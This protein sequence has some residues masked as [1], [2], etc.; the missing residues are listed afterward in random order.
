[1]RSRETRYCAQCN[2]AFNPHYG[3]P[4]QVFCSRACSLLKRWGT[5]QARM[6]SLCGKP[7]I[8][9]GKRTQKFCSFACRV[10]SQTGKPRLGRRNR[11]TKACVQCLNDFSRPAS[12]FHSEKPFCSRSCMAE[13]QS[14]FNVGLAHPRWK[15]GTPR[16]YG[17]G[18]RRAK[19]GA[20]KRSGG[21]CEKCKKRPVGHV[22][23]MLP[24]RYFARLQDAHF[25]KNLLAVCYRCHATEHRRLSV[26]LPLLDR[27]HLKR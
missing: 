6:C 26:V 9:T 24:V 21:I 12:N 23:H 20:V 25:D 22:H 17:I 11:V 1:M 10:I 18:W 7:A 15:G 2:S 19:A 16:T 5:P 13:W 4:N 27:L 8:S 3:R 14:E